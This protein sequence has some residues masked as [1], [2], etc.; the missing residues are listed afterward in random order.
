[1]PEKEECLSQGIG[2]IHRNYSRMVNFREKTRGFLFQGRFFSCPLDNKHLSATL[3]YIGLNPVRAGMC[4]DASEYKWSSARFNLG[5]E[6]EDPLVKDRGWYGS[7]DGWKRLL[8]SNPKEIDVLRK[9]FRTGRPLGDERFLME[10]ERITG[11][12][13]MPKKPGRIR[14]KP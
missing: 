10:A 13:L 9:H 6:L 3:S 14:K 12:E 11:R 7:T 2:M 5:L 1:M 4:E 8:K